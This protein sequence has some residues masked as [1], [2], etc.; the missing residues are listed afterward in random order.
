MKHG[1]ANSITYFQS[2]LCW[3]LSGDVNVESQQ[4]LE[5]G[6]WSYSWR[7]LP[8]RWGTDWVSRSSEHKGMTSDNLIGSQRTNSASQTLT[9]MCKYA[10]HK[11]KQTTTKTR[12]VRSLENRE[13]QVNNSAQTWPLGGWWQSRLS[14]IGISTFFSQAL[15]SHTAFTINITWGP[16]MC[17]ACV[18]NIS[19]EE[20]LTNQHIVCPPLPRVLKQQIKKKIPVSKIIEIWLRG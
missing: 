19:G 14:T 13:M 1:G 16:T 9:Y 11:N 6:T 17:Q 15:L 3:L 4:W 10:H 18:L 5:S 20:K 2:Y 12:Q 7:M 8:E